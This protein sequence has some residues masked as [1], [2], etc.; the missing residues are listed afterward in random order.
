MLNFVDTHTHLYDA[1]YDG[2]GAG[3]VRR[4]IEASVTK[5]VMPDTEDSVRDAMFSL[6]DEFP[7]NAFP[8]LGLHPTEF[9]DNWR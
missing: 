3:A 6:C 5:L 2:E 1:A 7:E 8:C 4:A 9:K